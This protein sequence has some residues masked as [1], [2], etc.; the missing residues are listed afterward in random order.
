MNPS[1]TR[2]LMLQSTGLVALAACAT[3]K[4]GSVTTLE[5]DVAKIDGWG[6]ALASGIQLAANLPGIQGTPA[7]LAI[8]A[9]APTVA[10]DLRAFDTAAG[11]KLTLVIDTSNPAN[12]VNALVADGQK[13]ASDV[14]A[15]VPLA[16]GQSVGLVQTYLAA[17]NTIVALLQAAGGSPVAGLTPQSMTESQAMGVLLPK[18]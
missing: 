9:V 8:L 6:Q 10:T 11:G 15:A 12:F 7:G 5:V 2:R 16:I 3:T 17:I 4:T 1:L 18:R 13:L 14:Q